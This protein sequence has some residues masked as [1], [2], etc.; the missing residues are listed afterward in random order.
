MFQI[1]PGNK[2]DLLRN[3]I[4]LQI[5]PFG[6]KLPKASWLIRRI[7]LVAF[8]NFR[9]KIF[10]FRHKPYYTTGLMKIFNFKNGFSLL[11]IL[12]A[13]ALIGI[14]FVTLFL[15]VFSVIMASSAV[16]ATTQADFLIKE[17]L[18]ALR[19]FRDGTDWSVNGLGAVQT[20]VANPYYLFLQVNSAP[21]WSLVSGTETVGS[22]TRHIIFK[23][24]FSNSSGIVNGDTA[25]ECLGC[26]ENPNMIKITVVATDSLSGKTYQ[27]VTY[28]SNWKK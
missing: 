27:I 1:F 16:K 4:L 10:N 17:E 28:L 3:K 25:T 26:P 21:T 6:C 18:E 24:V 5:K 22:F 11:E 13:V 19:S 9:H 8:S 7:N 15:V 20:G 23:K 14:A 12:I 2:I